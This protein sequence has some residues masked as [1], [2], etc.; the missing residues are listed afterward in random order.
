[1]FVRLNLF[2]LFLLVLSALGVVASQQRARQIYQ[3][4]NEEENTIRRLNIEFGQLELELSTWANPSR[5]ER[6]ARERLL[7]QEIARPEDLSKGGQ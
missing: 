3:A 2:L 5:I 1:M 4:L 6:L 7:M